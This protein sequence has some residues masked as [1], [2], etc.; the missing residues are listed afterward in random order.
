MK[1]TKLGNTGLDVSKVCLGCMSFGRPGWEV[2][3]WVLG[4]DDSMPFFRRAHEAGINFLD[5]AEERNSTNPAVLSNCFDADGNPTVINDTVNESIPP[6]LP[7]LGVGVGFRYLIADHVSVGRAVDAQDAEVGAT[8]VQRASDAPDATIVGAGWEL[9]GTRQRMRA[10]LVSEPIPADAIVST[11]ACTDEL[12]QRFV[13]A[14]L[15]LH[16]SP[17]GAQVLRELFAVE[18]FEPTTLERYEA[19]RAAMKV[20]A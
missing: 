11:A 19:V 16:Q 5:T 17:D 13:V 14:L 20:T 3:P 4:R 9:S 18:R 1:Y 10:L 6:V 7:V 2:H 15:N 8:F 12:R